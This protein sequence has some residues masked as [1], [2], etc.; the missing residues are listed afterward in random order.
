MVSYRQL[1]HVCIGIFFY[2]TTSFGQPFVSTFDYS[3]TIQYLEHLVVTVT[4]NVTGFDTAIDVTEADRLIDDSGYENEHAFDDFIK[5]GDFEVAITSPSNTISTLLFRR[6]FD[7][8]NTEGYYQWPLLTVLHWGENPQGKWSINVN[9]TNSF[10]MGSGIVGD[11]S[12]TLYG[13]AQ[14]PDSVANIPETCNI[15]CARPK[16]CSGPEPIE[17]DACNSNTI[18]N[19]TSLECIDTSECVDPY[20]VSDG[21]CFIPSSASFFT[22]QYVLV[23]LSFLLLIYV[24]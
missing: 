21:Y 19:A 16:G 7:I 3:G 18:R 20:T 14:V 1:P 22:G 23:I 8:V 17:C 6:P 9:W 11:V 13:V 24:F 10:P 12:A 15:A 5:R 2:R 4:L